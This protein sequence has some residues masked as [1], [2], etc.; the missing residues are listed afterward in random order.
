[1][2]RIRVGDVA[3]VAAG[4]VLI[5]A[6]VREIAAVDAGY[7]VAGSDRAFFVRHVERGPGHFG[8]VHHVVEQSKPRLRVDRLCAS[9]VPVGA[10]RADFRLCAIIEHRATSIRVTRVFH[11]PV[12]KHR[13]QPARGHQP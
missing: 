1:M 10:R 6:S 11:L 9:H 12:P 2:A 8:P 4:I 7:R 13:P 3:L 5:A